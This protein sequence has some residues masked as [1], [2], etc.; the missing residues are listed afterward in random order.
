[1]DLL[2]PS[3]DLIIAGTVASRQGRKNLHGGKNLKGGIVEAE[4]LTS[5]L[6]AGNVRGLPKRSKKSK[7]FGKSRLLRFGRVKPGSKAKRSIY[8][9][10][11]LHEMRS[12]R[13]R[14]HRSRARGRS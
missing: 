6:S 9:K 11:K 12:S 10:K 13:P 8:K 5:G 2:L 7:H 3:P 14:I 1:M 4:G